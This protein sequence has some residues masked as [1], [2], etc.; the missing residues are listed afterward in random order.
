MDLVPGYIT[1]G[2]R[3]RRNDELVCSSVRLDGSRL[4]I[5]GVRLKCLHHKKIARGIVRAGRIFAGKL[6]AG[7]DFSGRRQWD[8]GILHGGR[9]VVR[10]IAGRVR[11][12]AM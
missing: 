5:A 10:A 9:I 3:G 12:I 2:I 6:S 7:G 4:R 8:I 1:S 11:F